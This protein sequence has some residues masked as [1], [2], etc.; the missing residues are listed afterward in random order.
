MSIT[1]EALDASL[2]ALGTKILSQVDEK[3]ATLKPAEKKAD[4]PAPL[5]AAEIQAAERKRCTELSALAKNTGLADWEKV[6]ADWVDKGLSVLEAKAAIGELALAK[7]GLTKD[8]G[9]PPADRD[10][11]YK[12]EYQQ[13]LAA[14]VSMGLSEQEYIV[15]R[16]IDDG[17]ELLAPAKSAA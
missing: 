8:S 1:Q 12:A 9:D 6:G 11:K 16:K 3:L 7:N 2:A 5:S 4:E 10:A 17:T 15:S 14:F 13:Q